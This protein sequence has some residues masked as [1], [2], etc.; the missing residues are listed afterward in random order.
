MRNCLFCGWWL[1]VLWLALGIGGF[2]LF[3]YCFWVACVLF[4]VFVVLL[5]VVFLW[6][7]LGVVRLVWLGSF[8]GCCGVFWFWFGAF[9]GGSGGG[10]YEGLGGD[11][12]G[13]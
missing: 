3:I 1:N 10:R 13:G 12:G 5:V 7:G 11:L 8:T 4:L 9:A 2:I 6:W